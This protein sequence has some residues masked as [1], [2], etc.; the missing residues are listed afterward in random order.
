[1]LVCMISLS[2]LAGAN[3]DAAVADAGATVDTVDATVDGATVDAMQI[4]LGRGRNIITVGWWRMVRVGK[5]KHACN[6]RLHM[7]SGSHD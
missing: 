4:Y 3:V 5:L 1:M 7:Y 6:W 2:L